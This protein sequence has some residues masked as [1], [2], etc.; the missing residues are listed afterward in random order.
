M[1]IVV[2]DGYAA[3]AGD[4]S[5]ERL[6]ALGECMV[7]PRTTDEQL[8]ERAANAEI[9]LTNKVIINRTTIE[10]LPQLKYIGVLATGYNVVDVAAA[11][12]CL[13]LRNELLEKAHL[14]TKQETLLGGGIWVEIS[15]VREPRRTSLPHGSWSQVLWSWD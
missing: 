6:E 15:R 5:W 11:N 1:K 3:N 12:F 7:Y 10:A 14:L 13:T 8:L 2:L 9:L 4:L